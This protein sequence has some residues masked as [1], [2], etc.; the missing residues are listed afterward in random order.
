MLRSI[1]TTELQTLIGQRVPLTLCDVR[2]VEACTK[3]PVIIPGASWFDPALID[4]WCGTLNLAVEVVVYCVHGHA[5]SQ[6]V[7]EALQ[8]KGL[9]SRFIEGG[10]EAWKEAGGATEP[11]V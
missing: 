4:D 2:R 5:I 1:T 8:A 7:A 6:T 9:R 3:D 11:R 10:L